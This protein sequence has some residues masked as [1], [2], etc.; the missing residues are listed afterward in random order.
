VA[1]PKSITV[2]IPV[3]I[4]TGQFSV[5]EVELR[6]FVELVVWAVYFTDHGIEWKHFIDDSKGFSQD[7]RRPI[8]YASRRELSFYL[9]YARELMEDE[10]SGIPVR[11]I[12][13]LRD[14]LSRLNSNV[15]AGRLAKTARAIPPH[16]DMQE[17]ALRSFASI[18]RASFAGCCVLLAAYRRKK[19][20]AMNAVARDH[21]DWLLGPQLKKDVRKGPFGLA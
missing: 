4:A 8:T 6:R 9:E 16:D 12:G 13:K 17:T 18:Q 5:A 14:A 1:A 2:R 11:A 20:D 21:F 15:H 7:Q 10:P 19:F 3:L